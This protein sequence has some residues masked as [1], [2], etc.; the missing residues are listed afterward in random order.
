ME[1]DRSATAT[2]TAGSA[3]RGPACA[4]TTAAATGHERRAK[5]AATASPTTPCNAR[6]TCSAGRADRHRLVVEHRHQLRAAIATVTTGAAISATARPTVWR[7]VR[8]AL[9]SA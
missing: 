3:T 5:P 2:A 7:T 8:S 4:R 6:L 9:A 1:A